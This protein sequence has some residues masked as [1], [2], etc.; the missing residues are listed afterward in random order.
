VLTRIEFSYRLNGTTP[1]RLACARLT[2]AKDD[3]SLGFG[4]AG[5]FAKKEK[6]LWASM[7]RFMVF[8]QRL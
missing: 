3:A 8:I 1:G 4:R 2:V 6:P 7:Q 5:Q